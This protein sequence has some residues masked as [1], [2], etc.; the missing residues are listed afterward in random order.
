MRTV[1][2]QPHTHDSL[3]PFPLFLLRGKGGGAD[4]PR[5][6]WSQL[7]AW[8]LLQGLSR[9]PESPGG[10][11]SPS[12]VTCGKSRS[13]LWVAVSPCVLSILVPPGLVSAVSLKLSSCALIHAKRQMRG[14]PAKHQEGTRDLLQLDSNSFEKTPYSVSR[15]P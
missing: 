14:W 4:P 3:F 15:S 9:D 11:S 12:F 2:N 6:S 5:S 10:F 7:A 13:L 8:P 1:R